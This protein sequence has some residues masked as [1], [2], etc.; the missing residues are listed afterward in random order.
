VVVVVVKKNK[1]R[2]EKEK[3]AASD[4]DN[5]SAQFCDLKSKFASKNIYIRYIFMY[6]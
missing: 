2:K 3:K 6:T 4:Q 1:K 5:F